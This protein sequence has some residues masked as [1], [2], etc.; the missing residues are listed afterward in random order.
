MARPGLADEAR[1]EQ[2]EGVLGCLGNALVYLHLVELR[3]LTAMREGDQCGLLGPA[4]ED[5]RRVGSLVRRA[6]VQVGG[7]ARGLPEG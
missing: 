3:V 4:V 6:Q 5:L 1:T 7:S 2:V